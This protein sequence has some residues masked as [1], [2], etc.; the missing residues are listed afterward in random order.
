MFGYIAYTCSTHFFPHKLG[1]YFIGTNNIELG[2]TLTNGLDNHGY[3]II[4]RYI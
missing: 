4:I 3:L 2:I 1:Q